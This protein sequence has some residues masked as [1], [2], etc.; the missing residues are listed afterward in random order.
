MDAGARGFRFLRGLLGRR[1]GSR[2]EEGAGAR[3]PE[4]T[5][6]LPPLR[7]VQVDELKGDNA[8]SK[9][10]IAYVEESGEYMYY[11]IEPRLSPED[12]ETLAKLKE[13]LQYVID[14]PRDRFKSRDEAEAYVEDGALKALAKFKI[15]VPRNRLEKVLYYLKRD[16]VGFGKID[17]MM[18]DPYVEDVSCDGVGVPIYVWHKDFE[19]IRSNV[20]F[21]TQE[22]LNSVVLR[23]AYISGRAVSLANPILDA[24]LPDG[25]RVNAVLGGQVATRG[26]SFTIR[27]FTE[28]PFTIT[29]LIIRGTLDY[30]TAAYFW[31]LIEHKRNI[32]IAGATASGKTTT[33][34]ALAN[35]I[36]PDYKVVTIEDT[37][38][39]RLYHQNW[40]PLLTRTSW[41]PEG[42]GEI[43]AFELLKASFRQRPDYIIVGEV[44]G[45]EAYA[46]IQAMATGHGGLTT[47]HADD[48]EAVISRLSSPP[49]SAP[50]QLIASS[51]DAIA[52]QRRIMINGRPARR[53]TD[54]SEVAGYDAPTD[55]VILRRVVSWDPASDRMEVAGESVLL[56]EIAEQ[57]GISVDAVKRE[58]EDKSD[59][60]RWMVSRR[61]LDFQDVASVLRSYYR[62]RISVLGRVRMELG[63]GARRARAQSI[64]GH[65]RLPRDRRAPALPGDRA[66]QGLLPLARADHLLGLR[67]G[68]GACGPGADPRGRG[69]R[70]RVDPGR[71]GHVRGGV[72]DGRRPPGQAP[73]P[74]TRAARPAPAR[75]RPPQPDGRAPEARLR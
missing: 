7:I 55:T 15:D 53:V 75:A 25:S 28:K 10:V 39:L 63:P 35:F 50:K 62:D 3:S 4:E 61:M 16:T 41:G 66:R 23:L 29:E 42:R 2:A 34:G 6:E 18:R 32:V 74:R 43:D 71:G 1:P 59:V 40:T 21:N 46:L 69:A 60:L 64:G 65:L 51:L 68:R 67:A 22:E 31:E 49:I 8:H 58:I 12:A 44:R 20:S 14:A 45:Q 48:A 56:P 5:E 19:S 38:E 33:L 26:G 57:R 13:L 73:G 30:Y 70:L 52:M 27:K 9:A 37:R 47:I 24:T 72:R 54:V 36:H 11:V 17:V